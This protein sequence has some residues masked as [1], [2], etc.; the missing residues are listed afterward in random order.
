ML[1]LADSFNVV[2][3]YF[4]SQNTSWELGRSLTKTFFFFFPLKALP[5]QESLQEQKVESNTEHSRHHHLTA[6]P[7]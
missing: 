2:Y 3:L 1:Q 5:L 4:P 6:W 7:V